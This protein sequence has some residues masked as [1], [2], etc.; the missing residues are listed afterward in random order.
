M[1]IFT[2]IHLMLVNIPGFSLYKKSLK[3]RRFL[4]TTIRK[5]TA[6]KTRITTLTVR[7]MDDELNTH[8]CIKY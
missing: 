7:Q 6:S 4:S 2:A 8:I 3:L 1:R 5:A